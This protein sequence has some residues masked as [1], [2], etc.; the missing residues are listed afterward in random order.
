MAEKVKITR[1]DIY[2]KA[3]MISEGVR[4]DVPGVPKMPEDGERMA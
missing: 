1:Q 4:L 2:I 3:R